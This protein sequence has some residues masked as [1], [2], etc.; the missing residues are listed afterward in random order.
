MVVLC[1]DS[2]ISVFWTEVL[3]KDIFLSMSLQELEN[4]PHVHRIIDFGEYTEETLPSFREKGPIES[5]DAWKGALN[6]W[7]GEQ[8]AMRQS[9]AEV[10]ANE[11]GRVQDIVRVQLPNSECAFRAFCISNAFLKSQTSS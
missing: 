2:N 10:D 8:I 11:N 9:H 4:S 5:L 6:C 7:I 1:V 3:P